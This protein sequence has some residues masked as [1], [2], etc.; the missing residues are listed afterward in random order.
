MKTK[1]VKRRHSFIISLVRPI[2][3]LFLRLKY[4]MK[5]D[6]LK[7]SR[8]NPHVII[9]NHLTADDQFLL[10]FALRGPFYFVGTEDITSM[11]FLSKLL[12]YAVNVIPFKKSTRD[13]NAVR[14]CLKTIKEGGSVIIFP[15]G[16]RSYDG[17]T[18]YIKPS[19]VKMI[20]KMKVPVVMYNIKGGYGMLPRWSDKRRKGLVEVKIKKILT[21]DEYKDIDADDFYNLICENLYWDDNNM[22]ELYKYKSKAEYMERVIYVCPNCGISEFES[23][24][25]VFK[26]KKCGN[27]AIYQEDMTFKDD[28]PFKNVRDWYIY[29]ENYI[30][31]LD[32][33]SFNNN[34]IFCDNDVLFLNVILYKKKEVVFKKSKLTCYN[35]RLEVKNIDN[36]ETIIY[37]YRDVSAMTCLGKNK[38]NVYINDKIYQFKGP[39]RFNALKYVNIFYHY[40]NENNLI[41]KEEYNGDRKFLGL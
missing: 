40:L 41:S 3:Y 17:T 19:I 2:G 23:N 4:K 1:Y 16:N 12:K 6:K 8:K 29:Q 30:N 10:G 32:L 18:C 5:L 38:F 15:E 22:N 20:Y 36:E 39:T 28:K 7:L 31:N 33:N 37:N 34:L 27:E 13:A 26:C 35:D 9:S 24:G 14:M 21:Y 11:G 25:D